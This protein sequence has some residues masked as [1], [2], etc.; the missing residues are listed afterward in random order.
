MRIV[1]SMVEIVVVAARNTAVN[2]S[3]RILVMWLIQV[4][5][6][7][8]TIYFW[9]KYFWFLGCKTVDGDACKFPFEYKGETIESCTMADSSNFWCATFTLGGKYVPGLFGECGDNCTKACGK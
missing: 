4:R 8:D 7:I 6:Q 1:S 3:V 9:F 2:A 5:K